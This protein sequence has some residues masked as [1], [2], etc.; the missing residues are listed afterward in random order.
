[1]EENYPLPLTGLRHFYWAAKL[2]SFKQAAEKL[3]V[4]EAAI[5]QQIRK[6]ESQLGIELFERQ[7][8]KVILSADGEKLFPYVQS[9]FTSLIQGIN[10]L[11]EDPNPNRLN[12]STMPSLATH[13]LIQRLIF[14]NEIHPELTITMDTSV[15]RKSFEQG[16]LDLAIRYGQGVYPGL[17]SILLMKD[18]TVLVCSPR[19]LKGPTITRKDILSLPMIAGITDGVRTALRN[20]QQA[21]GI[22]DNELSETLLLKDGSLGAEAARAGQGISLQR[23]S[24]VAD[25]IDAGEL[26]FSDDFAFHGYN[27]YAV[28]PESHFEKDKVKKFMA[29]LSAEMKKTELRIQPLVAQLKF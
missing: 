18:P 10:L 20:I 3:F 19:L 15:E 29:W 26:V 6:V 8:Q 1:M 2:G 23:L 11:A 14:F 12:I 27:F 16:E 13:W 25:M 4:S 21:Y 22:K 9:A 17:K 7:H 24:L 28:A 5:S